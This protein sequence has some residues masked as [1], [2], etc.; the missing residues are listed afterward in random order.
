[1]WS[2]QKECLL[3]AAIAQLHETISH[4]HNP[5]IF[6]I[7]EVPSR[8]RNASRHAAVPTHHGAAGKYCPA[9]GSTRRRTA[10]ERRATAGWSNL[11]W[12]AEK[13]QRIEPRPEFNCQFWPAWWIK[14][15]FDGLQVLTSL[16]P[17]RWVKLVFDCLQ[18]LTNLAPAWWVK[19]VFDCLQVLTSLVPAWW[20]KL[21]LDCYTPA[22]LSNPVVYFVFGGSRPA[23]NIEWQRRTGH[24]PSSTTRSDYGRRLLLTTV[25]QADAGYYICSAS[26]GVGETQ[27]TIHLTVDGKSEC[28]GI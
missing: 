21:A 17:A 22:A 9:D 26:N 1:M 8:R 13:C 10:T 12:T 27:A 11:Q 16:A 15:V 4:F 23:V 19:L 14:L 24:L 18:V 5:V 6:I 20:V 2:Q 28:A 25:T 7:S 3:R